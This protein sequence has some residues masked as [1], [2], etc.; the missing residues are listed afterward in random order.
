LQQQGFVQRRGSG[1]NGRTVLIVDDDAPAREALARWLCQAGWTV[2]P[3]ATC[4]DAMASAAVASLDV[5]IV[6]QRLADGSGLELFTRL[7]ALSPDMFG[8]VLTRY[9][10][11]AAAVHAIRIGFRDYLPKPVDWAQLAA[12]FEIAPP[13]T[14]VAGRP[15][16]PEAPPSLARVE[17]EHIQSVLFSCG[18]NVSAAARQLG[19]HRR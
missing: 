11:I 3:A 5:A 17:W 16:E 13:S 9:P 2:R 1:A 12:L 19:M 6:E 4:A 7:R 15:P 8:V 18:G 10:S 14:D